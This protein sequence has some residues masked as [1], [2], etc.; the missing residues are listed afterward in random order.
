MQGI[1]EPRTRGIADLCWRRSISR[2][3]RLAVAPKRNEALERDHKCSRWF[4]RKTSITLFA[5]GSE[6]RG[7][8]GKLCEMSKRHIIRLSSDE[9]SAG[10]RTNASRSRPPAFRMLFDKRP[11][12]A[13]QTWSPD[14]RCVSSAPLFFGSSPNSVED[15][16]ST[17]PTQRVGQVTV[18]DCAASSRCCDGRFRPPTDGSEVRMVVVPTADGLRGCSP[19]LSDAAQATVRELRV[20]GRSRQ[21]STP[22]TSP[23]QVSADCSFR[24]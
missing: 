22:A 12:R 3:C 10:P 5:V 7:R 20:T 21:P 16:R 23:F 11:G 18:W 13:C 4:S 6:T 8:R 15:P 19:A 9:S 17:F 2:R 1:A 14:L 24:Y